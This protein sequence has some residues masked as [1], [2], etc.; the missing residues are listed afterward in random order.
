MT[1]LF[2][3]LIYFLQHSKASKCINDHIYKAMKS[4]GI[5]IIIFSNRQ[6]DIQY[7]DTL[8]IL[9]THCIHIVH[10]F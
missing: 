5:K 7:H 10:N 9:G 6:S 8:K 4:F 1:E 3:Y 2:L